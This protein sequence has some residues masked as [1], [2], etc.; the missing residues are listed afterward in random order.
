MASYS[1]TM[2]F[3]HKKLLQATS[4]DQEDKIVDWML[5]EAK[6][7]QTAQ[8]NSQNITSNKNKSNNKI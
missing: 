1:P 2:D 7:K 5:A 4:K 8:K 6:L 3:L